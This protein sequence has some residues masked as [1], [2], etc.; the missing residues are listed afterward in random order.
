M[1]TKPQI[2]VCYSHKDKDHC[3]RLLLFL[4][5]LKRKGLLDW[6]ADT[7]LTAGDKW[8]P[9]IAAALSTVN[10]AVL[11]ISQNFLNSDFILNKEL[12]YLL[13]KADGGGL[14]LIP[15]FLSPSN[16]AK[17]EARLTEFQGI[18]SPA[19]AL[20]EMTLPD[21]EKEYSRLT[22]EILAVRPA[23]GSVPPVAG[24]LRSLVAWA[25]A[26]PKGAVTLAAGA[27]TL[28]V[29]LFAGLGYLTF[30]ENLAI[31]D[32]NDSLSY[33]MADLLYR[34]FSVVP[35]LFRYALGGLVSDYPVLLY[36]CWSS[37]G[38][39]V[40]LWAMQ[41]FTARRGPVLLALL[42]I[43][44]LG[45]PGIIFF[46]AVI[47]E[48]PPCLDDVNDNPLG[49]VDNDR[50]ARD[51]SLRA[52]VE[53]CTW[54]RN[55]TNPINRRRRHDLAGVGGW[56]AVLCLYSAWTGSRLGKLPILLAILRNTLL[57]LLLFVALWAIKKIPRGHAYA[58]WGVERNQVN[59]LKPTCAPALAPA[60]AAAIQKGDC[61]AFD[62][63]ESSSPA[64]LFL[65][66]SGCPPGSIKVTIDRQCLGTV[67]D[68]RIVYDCL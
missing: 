25:L 44:I 34:G 47:E 8:G 9:D 7:R 3:D 45:A 51:F 18:G 46:A 30:R 50:L 66:G 16:V 31:L 15:V 20:S 21:Q 53:A 39:I 60:L 40:L 13:E 32:L 17:V 62:V 67:S 42:L 26:N 12:P 19:K 27:A 63:V 49:A 38:L 61:C 33:P 36:A 10:T 35:T 37:I 1:A 23:S 2:F 58:V 56:I 22:E 43:G 48:S 59:S 24:R 54:I 4:D 52:S 29:A 28:M 68:P 5:P 6:W 64:L 11:L 14:R 57:L 55:G 41:R 65:Y